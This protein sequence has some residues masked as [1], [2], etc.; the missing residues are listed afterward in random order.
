MKHGSGTVIQRSN[1]R[2]WNGYFLIAGDKSVHNATSSERSDT[3]FQ[4]L[5]R[6]STGTL[7]KEQCSSK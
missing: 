7:S 6:A 1:A 5:S 4:A 2:V 3:V